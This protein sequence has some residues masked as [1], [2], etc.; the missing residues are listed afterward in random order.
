MEREL[1]HV[2]GKTTVIKCLG[3]KVEGSAKNVR[4]IINGQDI[5]RTVILEELVVTIEG[6]D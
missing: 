2:D 1:L 6:E 5:T 3:L 4:I